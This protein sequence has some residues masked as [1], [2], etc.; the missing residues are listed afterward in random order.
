MFLVPIYNAAGQHN[1]LFRSEDMDNLHSLPLHEGDLP[2]DSIATVGY[3]ISTYPYQ[4]S[5]QALAGLTAL[6]FNVLFVVALGDVDRD[7]LE[8]IDNKVL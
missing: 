4:G 1:F 8:E 7:T 6:S 3:A 2:S 5:N